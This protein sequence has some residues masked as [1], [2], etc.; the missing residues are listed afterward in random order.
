MLK[1]NI[2]SVHFKLF[3]VSLQCETIVTILNFKNMTT[4]S[5]KIEKALSIMKS[6]DWYWSMADYTNPAYGNAYGSMRA[7]VEVVA[8][9]SDSTI[10]KALRD[11]WTANYEFAHNNNKETFKA[12][13]AELMSIINPIYQMAA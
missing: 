10:V 8:T 9:I 6:H 4:T 2:K 11:L 13:E 1:V 7:F 3:F 5:Q 12:K